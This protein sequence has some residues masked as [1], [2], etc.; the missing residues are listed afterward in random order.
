MVD[1]WCCRYCHCEARAG[2]TCPIA[3]IDGGADESG[4]WSRPKAREHGR[5]A[6]RGAAEALHGIS[7]RAA[8]RP[9]GLAARTGRSLPSMRAVRASRR[10][11][12]ATDVNPARLHKAGETIDRP[13]HS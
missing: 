2:A 3:Y 1:A 8:I 12:G 13:T 4:A 10:L 6:V 7:P 9:P 11:K 5:E